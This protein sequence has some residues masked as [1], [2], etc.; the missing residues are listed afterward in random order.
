VF[1]KKC[2]VMTLPIKNTELFIDRMAALYI[3]ETQIREVTKQGDQLVEL[4]DRRGRYTLC[5][6]AILISKGVG[7]RDQVRT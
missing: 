4:A 1:L 7:K 6:N 2:Q 3:R 5:R